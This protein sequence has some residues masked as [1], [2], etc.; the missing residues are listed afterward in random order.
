MPALTRTAVRRP[1]AVAATPWIV[2]GLFLLASLVTTGS[3]APDPR[4]LGAGQVLF[5]GALVVQVV[6][7]LARTPARRTSMAALLAGFL[8]WMTASVVLAASGAAGPVPFPAPGEVLF[9]LGYVLMAAFVFLDAVPSAGLRSLTAWADAVILVGGAASVVALVVLGPL[10]SWADGREL[11]V[12][13]ALVYPLLSLALAG[14]VIGQAA[15][16]MRPWTRR[17]AGLVLSFVVLAAADLSLAWTMTSGGYSFTLLAD[18]LWGLGFLL[19]IQSAC[20]PRPPVVPRLAGQVSPVLLIAGFVA[21]VLLLVVRPE[22]AVGLVISV[23]SGLVLLAA[24]VRAVLAFRALQRGS[25]GGADVDPATGLASRTALT[26]RIG[27]D[28]A[29][30][31]RVGILLFDVV[32]LHDVTA[33]F[34]PAAADVVLRQ[35]A[36]SMDPHLPEGT[37][38]AR[39]G[40][41]VGVVVGSDDPVVLRELAAAIRSAVPSVMEVEGVRVT[42]S[43]R[44]GVAGTADGRVAGSA[45]G[46]SG[47]DALLAAAVAAVAE[48]RHAPGGVATAGG[49][50]APQPRLRL[51]L[52]SDLHRALRDGRLDVWYQPIIVAATGGVDRWEAL[53]RWNHPREGMVPPSLFLPLARR[54][55]LMHELSLQVAER[56]AADVT[57]WRRA[58]LTVA[59]SLNLGPQ[60]LLEG[61]LVPAIGAVWAA[62]ELDPQALTVEITEDA[63]LQAPETARVALE[64]IRRSGAFVSI[65]HYGA[66]FSSLAYVRD[67]PVSEVKLDRAFFAGVCTD[68][69]SAVIVQSTVAM[70]HALG[71]SVVAEGIETEEVA[72][73]AIVLGVDRLQ[74]YAFSAPLPAVAVPMFARQRELRA[75]EP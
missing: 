65:D 38:V 24:A 27:H 36:G 21:T 66:G 16:G 43:L 2:F 22:G 57:G 47:P 33:A 62:H 72:A 32:H 45:D 58:G 60:E 18:V 5:A 69:R 73:R 29:R 7:T 42:V 25:A 26:R 37:L 54:Q 17:A 56:V 12:L 8:A 41:D 28:L 23:A 11:D 34:G 64:E 10:A 44:V 35:V 31:R 30:H 19:L 68:Q 39:V 4:L 67:L 75:P 3:A 13:V 40:D 61:R 63:F 71:L 50:A 14:L 51:Q 55:G 53:V 15:L 6:V 46:V 59:A 20:S 74:G 9:L 70:A 49:E 52:S 48:A 1:S